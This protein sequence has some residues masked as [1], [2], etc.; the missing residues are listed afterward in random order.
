MMG[1]LLESLSVWPFTSELGL[2]A[3]QFENLMKEVR[4]ELQ[5]ADLKLYV[6]M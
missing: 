6:H 2:T 3:V 5:N 4:I 1:A